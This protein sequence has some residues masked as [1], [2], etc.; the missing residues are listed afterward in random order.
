[1]AEAQI[2]AGR[3][4]TTRRN[5][6]RPLTRAGLPHE[7]LEQWAPP[8]IAADLIER[9]LGLPFVRS[10]QSRMALAGSCALSLPDDHANGPSEAF[11][12]DH[13]FC[14]LHPLPKGSLHLTLPYDVRLN[15]IDFG[16]AEPHP[17]VRSG[18]VT[19]CLVMVYAPRDREELEMVLRL[20]SFSY[21]FA[22]WGAD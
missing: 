20:I 2:V 10:R 9:S 16:W 17:A 12:D 7:Q 22:R 5:G 1:M 4:L 14:H 19:D 6:P 13:E 8:I 21:E 11:I 18:A 3:F 15:A